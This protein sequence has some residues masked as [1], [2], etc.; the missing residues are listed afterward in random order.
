M[1]RGLTQRV[2]QYHVD[3]IGADP[4]ESLWLLDSIMNSAHVVMGTLPEALWRHGFCAEKK[5][6]RTAKRLTKYYNRKEKRS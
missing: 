2:V 1:T 4:E 3:K 6:R 5:S